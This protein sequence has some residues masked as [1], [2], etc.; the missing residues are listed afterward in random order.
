[1]TIYLDAVWLLNVLL[2]A[3]ILMLTAAW[4]RTFLRKR[5]IIL[6]AIFASVIVPLSVYFPG[7]PLESIPGKI[8]F[9]M[10]VV[11][12]TFDFQ[13]I[14]MFFQKWLTFY[15]ATFALGGGMVGFYFL[16]G[17]PFHIQDGILLTNRTG[18]GAGVTWI[19]VI[20]LFPLIWIFLHNRM[21]ELF[22]FKLKTD[23]L[24]PVTIKM[25]G[26]SYSTQGLL[27][28]GN[29][30]VDPFSKRPVLLVDEPFIKQWF[31]HEEWQS[32]KT[33]HETFDVSLL[34]EKWIGRIHMIPYQGAKGISEF[35]LTLKPEQVICT[36]EDKKQIFSKV[37][38]GI[39]FGQMTTDESYHCLLHP[40]MWIDSTST[41]S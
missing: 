4:T 7:S 20:V 37:F 10:A 18:I 3:M 38:I 39:Q 19:Y 11:W 17:E 31:D 27:D 22:A 33:V 12:V 21:K 30:L 29:Q 9:S 6:G 14:R 23:Q 13:N 25:N 26:H 41:A 36:I 24:F 35:M 28:T 8:L 16:L 1:M 5:R 32:L 40:H 34:P 2:D 15:F